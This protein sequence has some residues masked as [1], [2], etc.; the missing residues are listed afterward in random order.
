MSCTAS[1]QPA[2]QQWAD[3]QLQSWGL[4]GGHVKAWLH[5]AA[6]SLPA[7]VAGRAVLVYDASDRLLSFDVWLD[8]QRVF[9]MDDFL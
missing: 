8:G 1:E 5:T 7:G 4:V 9:G 6:E 2:A 3:Q